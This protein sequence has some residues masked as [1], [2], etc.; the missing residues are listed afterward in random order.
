MHV[1]CSTCNF[2]YIVEIR[3]TQ[4]FL[5]SHAKIGSK[6]A[7]L[8]AD[9]NVL[10]TERNKAHTLLLSNRSHFVVSHF[11]PKQTAVKENN[12]SKV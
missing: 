6:V 3:A 2:I 1:A 12:N 4:Q 8:Q 10:R 9:E 7:L 11:G 5:M